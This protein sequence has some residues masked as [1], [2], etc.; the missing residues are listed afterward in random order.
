[1]YF[2]YKGTMAASVLD[3]VSH[4][5]C[6][7]QLGK[8]NK[9]RLTMVSKVPH[10]N[11]TYTAKRED[12]IPLYTALA[13]RCVLWPKNFGNEVLTMPVAERLMEINDRMTA[14]WIGGFFA[15]GGEALESFERYGWFSPVIRFKES[16]EEARWV[17]G[18]LKQ[19]IGGVI[20]DRGE[21]LYLHDDEVIRFYDHYGRYTLD[22]EASLKNLIDAHR[23]ALIERAERKRAANLKNTLIVHN[24]PRVVKSSFVQ[25][26]VYDRF[27]KTKPYPYEQEA[28]RTQLILESPGSSPKKNILFREPETP[29][30]EVI[31]LTADDEEEDDLGSQRDPLNIKTVKEE[32]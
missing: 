10:F 26:W 28:I 3:A 27:D 7:L 22:K 24:P 1:M 23:Q 9:P 18:C 19:R 4:S 8:R 6:E 30:A 14:Q 16:R 12:A 11:L 15:R 21:A 2:T 13:G 17:L 31:D 5:I 20:R 25:P 32:E 29:P